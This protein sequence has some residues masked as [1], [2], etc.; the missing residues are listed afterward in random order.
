MKGISRML[1]GFIRDIDYYRYLERI[2][3]DDYYYDRMNEGGRKY[4]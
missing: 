2:F 4:E 1:Y 3:D